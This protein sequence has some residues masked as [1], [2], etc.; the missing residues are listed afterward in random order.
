MLGRLRV[1]RR[2]QWT[3]RGKHPSIKDYFSI[4]QSFPL[5]K[6][7]SEWMERGFEG[8]DWGSASGFSLSSWRFWTREARRDHISCGILRDSADA[9]GRRYPLLVMGSGPLSD[10]EMNWDLIPFA[11]EGVWTNIE[12]LSTKALADL[13]ALEA[14][15]DNVKPPA[16]EWDALSRKREDFKDL[17]VEALKERLRH[18]PEN[19]PL[20]CLDGQPYDH[21]DLMGLCHHLEKAAIMSPPNVV[22]MGGTVSHTYFAPFR[23]ALSTS[24]FVNMW[25][26]GE[27]H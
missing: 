13:K 25:K 26:V 4:G 16:A 12:L 7:F 9:M 10:W 21:F 19:D 18:L 17:P 6:A 23:R 27:R 3:A 20:L 22:F 14:E 11:C 2:W 15:V 8:I 5:A 1:E 24:D